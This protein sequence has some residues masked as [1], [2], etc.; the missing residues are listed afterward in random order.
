MADDDDDDGAKPLSQKIEDTIEGFFRFLLAYMRTTAAMAFRW[1]LGLSDVLAAQTTR[2]RTYIYPFTYL[3]IGGFLFS[4]IIAAYPQGL[5]GI[6][7]LIWFGDDIATNILTNFTQAF[8]LSTLLIGGFPTFFAVVLLSG[9]A[10]RIETRDHERRRALAAAYR[11]VFG[12]Q[13]AML[14]FWTA[15]FIFVPASGIDPCAAVPVLCGDGALADTVAWGMLLSFPYFFLVAPLIVLTVWRWRLSKGRPI[16][17]RIGFMSVGV[18]VYAV[19]M[20]AYA[21]TA[22]LPAR[23]ARYI[24]PPPTPSV[25]VETA[26]IAFSP[27]ANAAVSAVVTF[28]NPT[29][30][31]VVIHGDDLHLTLSIDKLADAQWSLAEVVV[32]TDSAVAPGIVSLGP[33]A[34]A[35]SRIE[36]SAELP[37]TAVTE[38][39][40]IVAKDAGGPV[41]LTLESYEPAM[42][43][44]GYVRK[45]AKMRAN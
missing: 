6:A 37:A 33:H 17:R 27:G 14:F 25:S 41:V 42:K 5:L 23:V 21:T 18:L 9:L 45:I 38:I 1:R 2:S 19:I 15:L 36:A 3:V 22:S 11:Y 16:A 35:T 24:A 39:G 28:R 29:D 40:Q 20:A 31:F 43:A 12:Y 13:A 26:S 8:S 10:S 44:T 7:D 34:I 4:L 30:K 32:T